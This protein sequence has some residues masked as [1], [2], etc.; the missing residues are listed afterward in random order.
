[1]TIII[2]NFN[3]VFTLEKAATHYSA[4]LHSKKMLNTI[5]IRIYILEQGYHFFFAL[6][7]TS[8][9]GWN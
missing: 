2:L 9:K 5:E 1:M 3:R 7:E 8:D 6:R 4:W